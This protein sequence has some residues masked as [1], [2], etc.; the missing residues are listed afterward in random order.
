MRKSMWCGQ[1]VEYHKSKPAPSF[2]FVG[3]VNLWR[4]DGGS[5]GKALTLIMSATVHGSSEPN[6]WHF[7]WRFETTF[8]AFVS[9]EV[10]YLVTL[11]ATYFKFYIL[12]KCDENWW[13]I[14]PFLLMSDISTYGFLAPMLRGGKV[15]FWAL[16]NIG[17]IAHMS[18][19]LLSRSHSECFNGIKGNV[20]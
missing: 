16:T 12:R 7:P 6:F 10:R 19:S 1:N 5:K 15:T 8:C 18:R 17:L 11:W 2:D 13:S 4:E 20:C 9:I 3:W 14:A